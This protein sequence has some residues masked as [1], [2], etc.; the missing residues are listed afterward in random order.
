MGPKRILILG[1]GIA[2]LSAAY[3]LQKSGIECLVFEKESAVGGLCR[4]KKISGFTFDYD[5]HLLHFR[6]KNTFYFV[7]NLLENNLVKHKRNAWI[8]SFSRFSRFPFQANLHGLPRPV[9]KE[10]LR[11]FIKASNS[12]KINIFG[13]LTSDNNRGLTSDNNFLDW[14]VR[15]FGKGIARHFMIPYNTK[16][17]TIPPQELTCEWVDGFIP[18]PSLDEIIEGTLEESRRNLGYNAF[19]WYPKKGGINELS[20]ALASKLKHIFTNCEA[21][22]I[23]IKNRKIKLANGSQERFNFLLSTLPLPELPRL[24]KDMPKEIVSSCRRLRW[25]SIF[26]LNLGLRRNPDSSRHWLYFP[27]K[28]F[29]F[30]RIGLPKNFSSSVT[31][32]GKSSLYVEV[33]YSQYK[34]IDRENIVSKVIKDLIK[35]EIISSEEE[36]CVQ[37]INDIKYGYPIY[38]F[39]YRGAKEKILDYLRRNRIFSFGRYG[40]W[41]YMSMEDVML[42]GRLI[43]EKISKDA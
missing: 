32:K 6:H 4:S 9:V 7:R 36:I 33:S 11:E 17:W 18:V 28:N 1:G 21:T 34:P 3:H 22:E 37:D 14:I 10:C 20:L 30:F 24:I 23:D 16:F 8:Y 15:T 40:S 38:D 29:S 41:R 25:N 12:N 31:P 42:D 26:N 5:G 27:E 39:N 19:F 43:A 35:A 2:G 13:G